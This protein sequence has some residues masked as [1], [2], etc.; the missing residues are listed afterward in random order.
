MKTFFTAE[1]AFKSGRSETNQTL[2]GLQNAKWGGHEVGRRSLA[3]YNR[4]VQTSH[5]YRKVHSRILEALL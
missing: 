1:A 3:G 2:N 4:P 5:R